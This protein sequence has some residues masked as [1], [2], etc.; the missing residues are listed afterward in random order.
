MMTP[1]N[2]PVSAT[3]AVVVPRVYRLL[4]D[5]QE[6]GYTNLDLTYTDV[7]HCVFPGNTMGNVQARFIKEACMQ[8]ETTYGETM[9]TLLPRLPGA[10]VN[11]EWESRLDD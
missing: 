3:R 10:R 7:F 2:S 11:G 1:S 9:D 5:W 6:L 8:W 4:C